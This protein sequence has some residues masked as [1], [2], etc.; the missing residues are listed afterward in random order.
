VIAEDRS[1]RQ[2]AA[3]PSRAGRRCP[4]IV[5]LAA[6]NERTKRYIDVD[7]QECW[8]R[9]SARRVPLTLLV[10]LAALAMTAT[11]GTAAST[12]AT[13][14]V[15]QTIQRGT[16]ISATAVA[17]MDA[18]EVTEYLEQ[19]VTSGLLPGFTVRRST[20]ARWPR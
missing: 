16:L 8:R 11:A 12:P 7:R 14:Q 15:G 20:G 1:T 17:G 5:D 4:Q 9:L 3:D 18:G 19:G 6:T 13:A 10:L 2:R